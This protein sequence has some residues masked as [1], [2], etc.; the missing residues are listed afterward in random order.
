MRNFKKF[1]LVDEE[2]VNRQKLKEIRDY[3]PDLMRRV[4][5]ETLIEKILRNS[6]LDPGEKIRLITGTITKQMSS[7]LLI[8]PE[9]S[10]KPTVPVPAAGEDVP[11]GDEAAAEEEVAA[12]ED[13][14]DDPSA[15]LKKAIVHLPNQARQRARRHVEF[16]SEHSEEIGVTNQNKLV[17]RGESIP[18]SN[19]TDLLNHLYNPRKGLP[20]KGLGNLMQTLK[21][22][23]TPSS[24]I[25]N[26]K[27]AKEL[28][29]SGQG[30]ILGY[31]KLTKP[32]Y[33]NP[34]GLYKNIF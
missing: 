9:Q 23:H 22:I 16:L 14:E 21:A 18:G 4:R 10:K 12:E 29:Q 20:P 17:I 25:S 2:E 11:E 34:P 19:M 26:R 6:E 5:E 33:S 31:A 8:D 24:L 13:A 1:R 15:N 30:K 7:D 32:H 3:N 27:L 28:S